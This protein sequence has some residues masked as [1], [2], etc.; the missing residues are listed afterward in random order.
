MP[1][2]GDVLRNELLALENTL[3]EQLQVVASTK[4]RIT[5][6]QHRLDTLKY[7]VLTL[8]VEITALIFMAYHRDQPQPLGQMG[9][10]TTSPLPLT[11]VC[12]SWREIALR[13][14]ELWTVVCVVLRAS[15][16]RDWDQQLIDWFA[17][18]GALD[19]SLRVYCSTEDN[20]PDER[21]LRALRGVLETIAPKLREFTV[22]G[23]TWTQF[24]YLDAAELPVLHF[25]V[26]GFLHFDLPRLPGVEELPHS[27]L[28]E[29]NRCP[30]LRE[31]TLGRPSLPFQALQDWS[32]ITKYTGDYLSPSW[33]Q[34]MPALEHCHLTTSEMLFKRPSLPFRQARLRRL[35]LWLQ[36][37]DCNLSNLFSAASFPALES[38]DIDSWAALSSEFFTETGGFM[39]RSNPPLRSLALCVKNT[40]A[41]RGFSHSGVETLVLMQSSPAFV[42][43]F[44][45]TLGSDTN[46]FRGLQNVVFRITYWDDIYR[47]GQVPASLPVFIWHAGNAIAARNR[48]ASEDAARGVANP[49]QP[50][51]SF[52]VAFRYQEGLETQEYI[53]SEN[54]LRALR[55]LKAVGMDICFTRAEEGAEKRIIDLD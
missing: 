38:L 20:S 36:F 32:Q 41:L 5:A 51:A 44:F 39:E 13:T 50:L 17:R 28:F 23:M 16:P 14:P 7:P 22:S 43:A 4:T 31:I 49:I 42:R 37:T 10:P 26:L 11:R 27:S 34:D 15:L 54:E 29:R 33:W 2:T 25:P 48:L 21:Q 55:S 24:G 30:A 45:L 53:F 46:F 47:R 35:E 18:S 6:L 9:D 8:P 1:L 40:A 52:K 3:A 12:R 19:V